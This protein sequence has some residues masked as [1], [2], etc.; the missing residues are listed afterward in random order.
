[1]P[2]GPINTIGEAFEDIQ[3]KHLKMTRV[4]QHP[5]IGPIA[6]LRTPIN[7]SGFP[8][9]EQFARHGPDPGEHSAELLQELG[10]SA[11]QIEALRA[12]G[13]TT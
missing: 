1:V 9:P 13:V 10:Y 11:T 12:A 8:Q 6:L 4:A 2:C 7:L 3:V 5:V